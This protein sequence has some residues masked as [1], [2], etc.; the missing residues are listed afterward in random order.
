MFLFQHVFLWL[1][2]LIQTA[3]ACFENSKLH[4]KRHIR[5]PGFHQSYRCVLRFAQNSLSGTL[6]SPPTGNHTLTLQSKIWAVSWKAKNGAHILRFLFISPLIFCSC[7]C[8]F[9]TMYDSLTERR[10]E[11]FGKSVAVW[12]GVGGVVPEA[13]VKTQVAV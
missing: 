7:N 8:A 5:A 1:V 11:C 9:E 6:A 4:F 13:D 2:C 12:S 3:K 10:A